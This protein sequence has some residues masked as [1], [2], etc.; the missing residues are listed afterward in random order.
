MGKEIRS[1]SY[2]V[3]TFRII[4]GDTLQATLDLG[5]HLSWDF[6]IRLNGID[7]PEIHGASKPIGDLVTKVVQKW[8]TSIDA[9]PVRVQSVSIDEKYGRLLGVIIDQYNNS[10]NEFLIRNALAFQYDGGT[11][12]VWTKNDLDLAA[13]NATLL[14]RDLPW[15]SR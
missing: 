3:N 7:A 15:S 6:N 1:F 8:M 2:Y 5:F 9:Q 14:L 10:L 4:D 11:K 12:K 13:T